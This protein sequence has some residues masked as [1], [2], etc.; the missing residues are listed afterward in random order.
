MP[1]LL[2]ALCL[3]CF[4]LLCFVGFLILSNAPEGTET[5]GVGFERI[6]RTPKG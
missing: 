1:Q 4:A 6:D 2:P 5:D 3:L